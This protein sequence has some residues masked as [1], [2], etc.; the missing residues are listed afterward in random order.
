MNPV[1][2]EAYVAHAQLPATV[3][4]LRAPGTMPIPLDELVDLRHFLQEVLNRA[5]IG[6][7]RYGSPAARKKYMK[8]LQM[9]LA[10]Y[11]KTG[12]AERLF[13]IAVYAWLETMAPQH[14]EQHYNL[15][16]ESATRAELGG[17]IA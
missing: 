17:N 3:L 2:L 7:Q 1:R 6:H 5:C 11:I 14:P 13:N 8:R 16:A 4:E 15:T 10:D 9:E 12:N